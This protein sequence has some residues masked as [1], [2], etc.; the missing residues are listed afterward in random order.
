MPGSITQQFL[1][2]G[3]SMGPNYVLQ[4]LCSKSRNIVTVSTTTEVRE[5]N[6]HE[7]RIIRI[8]EKIWHVF[9]YNNQV[10]LIIFSH[11]FLVTIKLYTASKILLPN[12]SFTNMSDFESG[13]WL[14]Q[15]EHKSLFLTS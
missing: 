14:F 9:D 7:F 4:L 15:K 2:P 1:P 6:K 5:E 13:Q 3:A 10:L 11:R 8:L 12:G